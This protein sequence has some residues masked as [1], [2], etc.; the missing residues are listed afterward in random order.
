MVQVA[1]A[2]APDRPVKP[3][4]LDLPGRRPAAGPAA[5]GGI[6]VLPR[7]PEQHGGRPR[8]RLERLLGLPVLVALPDR[9]RGRPATCRSNEAAMVRPPAAPHVRREIVARPGGGPAALVGQPGSPAG[10]GGARCC[11]V[12]SPGGAARGIQRVHASAGRSRRRRGDRLLAGRGRCSTCRHRDRAGD[13][14]GSRP[15]HR[16]A[17]APVRLLLP[18]PYRDE[19]RSA[20]SSSSGSCRATRPRPCSPRL[21]A[22]RRR[23]LCASAS[24]GH[25]R[26]GGR[27]TRS[28][29]ACTGSAASRWA[30]ACSPGAGSAPCW[31]SGPASRALFDDNERSSAQLYQHLAL[32]TRASAARVIRQQPPDRR[33]GRAVRRLRRVSLVP[34]VRRLGRLARALGLAGA[35]RGAN[36]CGR[37][38]P[39]A[40]ERIPSVRG[41]DA[42]GRRPSPRAWPA[43][44][45]HRRGSRAAAG[46]PTRWPPAWTAPAS[47]PGSATATTAAACWSTRRNAVRRVMLDA[48]RA[49]FGAAPWWPAG[50]AACWARSPRSLRGRAAARHAR[51]DHVRRCRHD[52]PA[53]RRVDEVWLRC[54]AGPHGF[55]SIAAHGHADALSI[56]LRCGGRRRAGRPRN[57]LLSRR[58][59]LARLLPRHRGAQHALRRRARPGRI[60][61]PFLWLTDPVAHSASGCRPMR[62]QASHDG[63]RRLTRSHHR[64]VTLDG[65]PTSRSRTGSSAGAA[66][67][68][69]ARLPSRPGGRT[70]SWTRTAHAALAGRLRHAAL[71]GGARLARASRRAGPAARLV[72][73]RVRPA[74]AGRPLLGQ[75]PAAARHDASNRASPPTEGPRHADWHAAC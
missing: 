30:C 5:G 70:P 15:A 61:G 19:A 72:F 14:I 44:P 71:A 42:A 46:W 18:L 12:R 3:K 47:R 1:P 13:P 9:G 75:R 10:P 16:A 7:A 43:P 37:L 40:G 55:L 60:G 45:L 62:W 39:R 51:L 38:E 54:D 65:P 24:R 22:D 28:S 34:R 59:G 8:T 68:V 58:T 67:S 41:G 64:R 29:R 52:H 74:R 26:P 57:L 23:P 31:P 50:A 27:R 11:P 56:E 21:V 2:I 20:T 48:G 66:H 73:A 63:Y 53:H 49:L 32:P 4:K 35:G 17:R 69:A 33:T 6:V 36:P 25:L